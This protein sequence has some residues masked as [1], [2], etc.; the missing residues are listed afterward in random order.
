[1]K[2]LIVLLLA[3]AVTAGAFAQAAPAVTFGAYSDVAVTVY[4]STTELASY[5]PYFET[6][7]NYKNGPF[8]FSATLNAAS[9]ADV[10]AT[11]RN[12]HLAYTVLPQ[13]TVKAGRLR[14]GL[15]RLTSY[16][17]G[18]GFSTRYANSKDGVLAQVAVA[19]ATAG[20]FVPVTGLATSPVEEA[21]LAV[22]YAVP[23]MVTVVGGYLLDTKELWVGA[24]VKAVKGVTAKVGFKNVSE[25]SYVYLTGGTS[26]LVKDVTLGLD[27]DVNLTDSKYGVKV[28][29]A[30]SFKTYTAG[31]EVSFD[32]GDAW[33]GVDGLRLEPY[34]TAAF[35]P[36][37]IT[38][39]VIYNGKTSA[40][41][42]PVEFEMSF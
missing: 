7:V 21:H 26:S 23:N 9:T 5:S 13:L 2:K 29:G 30:Y 32:N 35:G 38:A 31:V 18:N 24:D 34:V 41:S 15:G 16:V 12:Y 22:Q 3:L 1:M 10:F 20:L 4:D 8:A 25:K 19:G 14:E 6:Y 36:G 37:S 40:W 28:L 11:P 17:D 33:N 42:V 39:T 27:A